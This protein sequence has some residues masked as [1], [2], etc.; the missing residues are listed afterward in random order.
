MLRQVLTG[1]ESWVYSYEPN[2]KSKS[3]MWLGCQDQRPQKARQPRSQKRSMLVA[4]FDDHSVV[5]MEFLQ[6]TV[7]RYVYT[8]VLGH[9]KER[10]RRKRPGMWAPGFGCVHILLLHHDNAPAH[11]AYHTRAH[12]CQ[13]NITTLEQPPYLPNLAPADYF[14]FPR[15]KAI[16]RGTGTTTFQLCRPQSSLPWIPFLLR[17]SER[18]LRSCLCAGRS[19]LTSRADILKD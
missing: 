17:T 14:F 5:H 13:S 7:N 18:P 3:Q 11:K 12:F 16:L 19:A 15:L 1:D 2:L 10:V 8:R 6:R 4:F 9:L